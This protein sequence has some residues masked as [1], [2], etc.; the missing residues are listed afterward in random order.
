[1]AAVEVLSDGVCSLQQWE[2]FFPLFFPL[3]GGTD[4]RNSPGEDEFR[5]EREGESRA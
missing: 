4:G 1:M 2:V 3:G 5:S